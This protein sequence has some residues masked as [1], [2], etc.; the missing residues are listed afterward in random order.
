MQ[1]FK[2]VEV[3]MVIT[4]K[5][6]SK[7]RQPPSVSASAASVV[8]KAPNLPHNPRVSGTFGRV[9]REWRHRVG[10]TQS[11]VAGHLEVDISTV[12]RVESGKRRPPRQAR[13]YDLLP[14]LPGITDADIARLLKAPDAP[15]LLTEI[16]QRPGIDASPVPEPT[17][18]S[19]GGLDLKVEVVS[20]ST[21]LTESQLERLRDIVKTDVEVCVLDC[22]RRWSA[23]GLAS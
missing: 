22:L 18:A 5:S 20:N 14:S 12:A 13:F 10:V 2:P 21:N 8:P 4:A 1:I 19:A 11:D 6:P 16:A 23:A 7:R 9:L 17:I 3:H 15:R